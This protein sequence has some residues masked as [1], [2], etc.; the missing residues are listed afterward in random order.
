MPKIFFT[1]IFTCRVF[2]RPLFLDMCLNLDGVYV[3]LLKEFPPLAIKLNVQ[4]TML[5]FIEF[6]HVQVI[7]FLSLSS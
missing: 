6:D 3:V 7:I 4:L 5:H 2:F 1:L